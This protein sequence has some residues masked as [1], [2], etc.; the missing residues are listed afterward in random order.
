MPSLH[1]SLDGISSARLLTTTKKRAQ[2]RCGTG[3]ST[4]RLRNR[5]PRSQAAK[6][7]KTETTGPTGLHR[8]KTTRR[9]PFTRYFVLAT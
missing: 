5:K 7:A 2:F 4:P 8:R 9:T 1:V 6:A 3:E